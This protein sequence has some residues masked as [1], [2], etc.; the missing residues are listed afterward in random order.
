[1]RL[2]GEITGRLRHQFADKGVDLRV[3]LPPTLLMASADGDRLAQVLINLIGNA[4]QYT[5]AAGEVT[6]SVWR[7]EQGAL[8]VI[9]DT[10]V[11]IAAEDLPHLFTRFYRVDKS[12]A[13][14]SGGSGIGLTIARHLVDAHHGRIWA[15]S[16]GVGEGSRFMFWL[17]LDG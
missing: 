10:G 4:L 8:F 5:P 3:N 15:E 9:A 13:R 1:M 11:G 12:R 2:V 16:D 6:V 7:E 14:A 17:P